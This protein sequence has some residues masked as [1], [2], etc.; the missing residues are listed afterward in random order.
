MDVTTSHYRFSFDQRTFTCVCRYASTNLGCSE[1]CC[2]L[3]PQA[4][5]G[6]VCTRMAQICHGS[7]WFDL[8]ATRIQILMLS[9]IGHQ[10]V[11][12]PDPHDRLDELCVSTSGKRESNVLSLPLACCIWSEM[13]V[14]NLV[15]SSFM[16]SWHN[17]F[18]VKI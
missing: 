18:L 14:F 3:T 1:L 17:R 13:D 9:L 5:R 10:T 6:S 2:L 15:R 12:S 7:Y 16:T 8:L 4:L 11:Q